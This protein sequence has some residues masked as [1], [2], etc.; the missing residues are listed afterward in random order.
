MKRSSF[1]QDYGLDEIAYFAFDSSGTDTEQLKGYQHVARVS[2]ASG[3]GTLYLPPLA[4]CPLMGMYFVQ[5]TSVAGGN[6]TVAP[7]KGGQSTA[8]AVFYENEGTL[9][10]GTA[11][12]E[13][14]TAANGWLLLMALGDRWIVVADDLDAS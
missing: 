9:G 11:T 4:D 13:A 12:S 6:V 1:V 8:E 3:A 10:G 5:A 14:I 2:G 7:F